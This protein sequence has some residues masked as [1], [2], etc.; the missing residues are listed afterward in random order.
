ML[1]AFQAYHRS[2]L[3]ETAELY[4]PDMYWIDCLQRH[5]MHLDQARATILQHNP[6]AVFA[7]VLLRRL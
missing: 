3:V 6:D 4:A 1:P 2:L 5:D 7:G